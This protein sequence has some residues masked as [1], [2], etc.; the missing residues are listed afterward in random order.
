M[1][2]K[3]YMLIETEVG[4]TAQVVEAIRGSKGVLS[5][6]VV[7]GPY[8]AIVILEGETL[9]GIGGLVTAQVHNISGI[10]RTVTCIVVKSS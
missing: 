3:A 7:T 2:V 5:V 1:P 10:S 9:E 4:K 8:D 6:D